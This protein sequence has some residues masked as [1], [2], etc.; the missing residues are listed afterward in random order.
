M[1]GEKERQS[2]VVQATQR[3]AEEKNAAFSAVLKTL[4]LG[5]PEARPAMTEAIPPAQRN[6]AVAAFGERHLAWCA[7]KVNARVGKATHDRF[8]RVF[9]AIIPEDNF[10]TIVSLSQHARYG[11]GQVTSAVESVH[12]DAHQRSVDVRFEL[13]CRLPAGHLQGWALPVAALA[14]HSRILAMA[15]TW[16][17]VTPEWVGKVTSSA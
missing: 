5:A 9:G 3:A 12:Y 6:G 4:V 8:G 17:S 2:F 11:L 14:E 10:P 15:S 16:S 13:V 7:E 1:A